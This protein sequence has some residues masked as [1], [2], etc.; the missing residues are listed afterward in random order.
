MSVPVPALPASPSASG[1]PLRP[2]TYNFSL[3][4]LFRLRRR[5][6]RFD[7]S[8]ACD[9]AGRVLSLREKQG[10]RRDRTQVSTRLSHVDP[11]PLFSADASLVIF[12]T[13][14]ET[15]KSLLRTINSNFNTLPWCRY[16]LLSYI[17]F[18]RPKLI[19]SLSPPSVYFQ[20]LSRP[21][22]RE[23]VPHG[24]QSQ[25]PPPSTSLS[26]ADSLSY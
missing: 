1:R 24:G 16:V 13:R 17:F 10:L 26:L 20:S 18:D 19:P 21:S 5:D 3:S 6:L 8:R 23:R 25:F 15:A 14:R 2:P 9:R 12:C 22:R 7:W 4:S 11:A